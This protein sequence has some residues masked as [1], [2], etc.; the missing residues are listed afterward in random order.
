MVFPDIHQI[1]DAGME[2]FSQQL[3]AGPA[4]EGQDLLKQAFTNYRN[5]ARSANAGAKIQRML[6]AD[7]QIGLHEQ[8]RLQPDIKA[9]M[10]GALLE[11]GDIADFLAEKLTGHEGRIGRAMERL[12]G[13]VE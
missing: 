6:L 13:M 2:S 7:L 8:I 4:P 5:A 11:P 1:S 9:A 12:W 3:T 10:D